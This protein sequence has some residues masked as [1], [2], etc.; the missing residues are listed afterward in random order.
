M[1]H[2]TTVA[3][4]AILEKTGAR[5]GLLTTEE[6]RDVQEI[7]RLRMPVLYDLA[8]QKPAAL[9]DR[10]R[11]LEVAGRIDHRVEIERALD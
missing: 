2:G 11:R 1:I 9:V 3:T 7:R 6:F 10:A 5:T 8:W 4:N